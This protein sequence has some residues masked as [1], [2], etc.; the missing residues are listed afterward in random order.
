MK[1][2]FSLFLIMETMTEKMEIRKKATMNSDTFWPMET[3]EQ[4]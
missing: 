4:W 3:V 1:R 2:N